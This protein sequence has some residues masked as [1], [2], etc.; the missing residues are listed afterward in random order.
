MEP[1]LHS[2]IEEQS[3]LLRDIYDRLVAQD[4]RWCTLESTVAQ[5]SASIHSLEASATNTSSSTPRQDLKI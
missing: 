4:T 3:R 5:N 1:N 2:A